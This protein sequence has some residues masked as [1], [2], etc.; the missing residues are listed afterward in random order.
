MSC[1]ICH[2]LRPGERGAYR[3]DQVPPPVCQATPEC[4]AASP[5]YFPQEGERK[6]I[7][8]YHPNSSLA[9]HALLSQY[10][11]A[12]MT[13]MGPE[14]LTLHNKLVALADSMAEVVASK[15]RAEAR[16]AMLPPCAIDV[17]I[18]L[19]AHGAARHRA[20]HVSATGG[21]QTAQDHARHRWEH[22]RRHDRVLVPTEDPNLMDRSRD[23]D[24]GEY[25][26]A[27]G[28]ARGLLELDLLLNDE[29]GDRG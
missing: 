17:V 7:R 28:V 22:L 23:P 29:G 3:L 21:G 12:V 16:L 2:G 13:G 8:E 27:H 1:P 15:N 24:T 14:A 18:K 25:D 20:P 5:N 4:K 26:L 19:L 11:Q 10:E 6:Q 9:V